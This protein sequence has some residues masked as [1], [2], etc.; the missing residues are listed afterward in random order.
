MRGPVDQLEDLLALIELTELGARVREHGVQRWAL[1]CGSRAVAANIEVIDRHA[2]ILRAALQ[3][4]M[5]WLRD[6]ESHHDGFN[7]T[8]SQVATVQELLAEQ[9]EHASR[10]RLAWDRA[11]QAAV[12]VG[13]ALFCV[14]GTRTPEEAAAAAREAFPDP[15]VEATAQ[16]RRLLTWT[17]LLPDGS[18]L[19]VRLD[20]AESRGQPRDAE[21]RSWLEAQRVLLMTD[22]EQCRFAVTTR[23]FDLVFLAELERLKGSS[24]RADPR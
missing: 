20:Y 17:R 24:A 23:C 10:R 8:F 4:A 12:A 6:R 21:T 7:N 18:D 5:R 11:I 9:R 22:D 15:E 3:A 14:A 13:E 16:L 1:D 19:L 2:P